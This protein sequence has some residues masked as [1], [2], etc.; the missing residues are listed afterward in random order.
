MHGVPECVGDSWFTLGDISYIVNQ[1]I[2]SGIEN[3]SK[4]HVEIARRLFIQLGQQNVLRLPPDERLSCHF[5][6]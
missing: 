5:V 6:G 3:R 2:A 1:S 4:G